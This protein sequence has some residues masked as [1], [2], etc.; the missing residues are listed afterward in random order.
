MVGKTILN[1]RILEKLGE[2]GM[3]V[4][5]KAMDLALGQTVAVRFLPVQ[6]SHSEVDRARSILEARAASTFTHPNICT[7]HA[8]KEHEGQMFIVMDY[9]EGETLRRKLT[10]GPVQVRRAIE[11]G[12][13]I[14]EGLAILHDHGM[15]HRNIKPENIMIRKDGVV[16]VMDFGLLRRGSLSPEAREGCPVGTAAYMSPE[17]IQGHASDQR[18]DIFSLGVIL[19]EML[20]GQPPFKG[21]DEAALMNDIMSVEPR[22][23]STSVEGIDKALDDVVLECLV[24]DQEER[25]QSARELAKNLRRYARSAGASGAERM[26]KVSIKKYPPG[27][28][29]EPGSFKA[30]IIRFARIPAGE[31]R[32]APARRSRGTRVAPAKPD[33]P[34]RTQRGSPVG[35]RSC[36]PCRLRLVFA[37]LFPGTGCRTPLRPLV[38]TPPGK[39]LVRESLRRGQRRTF[40]GRTGREEADVCRDRFHR[41]HASLG[42]VS[43]FPPVASRSP[44]RMKPPTRSGPRTAGTS[45][46]F[47]AGS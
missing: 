34:S 20:S 14:A 28:P 47:P 6:L 27:P 23:L 18:T 35:V 30:S 29:P 13:Q 15:I 40:C 5:Y 3:G 10:A 4:V 7:V 17:I 46:S 41:R 21:T 1:Y 42:P 31:R 38:H 32:G 22:P 11:I 39:L 2:G 25:Y 26:V 24:K 45:G 43:Q 36:V 37:S 44:V 33:P 16:Q 19:Y 8:I 9:V 12:M